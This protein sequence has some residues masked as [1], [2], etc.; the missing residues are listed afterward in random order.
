MLPEILM[1]N[2]R[3]LFV[4]ACVPEMSDDL[5]F[6][7]LTTNNRFWS[8]LEYSGLTPAFVVSA[9]ERSVLGNAKKDGVLTDMYKQFFFEKKEGMLL[10]HRIG[11]TALNRRRV[12]AAEDDREALATGEDAEKLSEKVLKYKPKIVAFLMKPE[13]FERAFRGSAPPASKDRGKQSFRIGGAEVWLLGSTNGRGKD[14]EI[15]EE[16]FEALAA[17][18]AELEKAPT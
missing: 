18:V 1:Q 8:L 3:V 12:Y 17:R 15:M 9:S 4:G 11:L 14:T 10:K 13:Q 5:G 6:Y 7:Y 16:L 2:L